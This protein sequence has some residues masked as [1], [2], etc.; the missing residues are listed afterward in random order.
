M[1]KKNFFEEIINVWWYLND[2]HVL[3]V[4][5]NGVLRCFKST[6]ISFNRPLDWLGL[7]DKK[8]RLRDVLTFKQSL[9]FYYF[10]LKG[11]RQR[12]YI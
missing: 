1:F 2:F 8:F 3:F 5:E 11:I 6:E 12:N 10:E 9:K 4:L 7:F